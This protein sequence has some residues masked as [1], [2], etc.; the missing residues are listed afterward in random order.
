MY[1]S[2]LIY[3]ITN[4]RGPSL[5]GISLAAENSGRPH[6]PP[7]TQ[8][9]ASSSDGQ[10]CPR[11]LLRCPTGISKPIVQRG[12]H[13]SP[14]WN[15]LFP[16]VPYFIKWPH[17]LPRCTRQKPTGSL[18]PFLLLTSSIQPTS[19]SVESNS[20]ITL[21]LHL[22]SFLSHCHNHSPRRGHV[23]SE[24]PDATQSPTFSAGGY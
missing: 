24:W 8:L 4:Q 23:V 13:H 19:G 6:L 20:N 22:W 14:S 18:W 21:G 2:T 7:P 5:R 17:H 10:L 11:N 1:A 16:C 9:A 3:L 12:T 15:P